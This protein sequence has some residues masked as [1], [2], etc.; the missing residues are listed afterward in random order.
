MKFIRET[1]NEI[2]DLL[3]NESEVFDGNEHLVLEPSAGDGRIVDRLIFRG[4]HK[5]LI[6]CVEL[7]EEK[8]KILKDKGYNAVREDFLKFGSVEMY[9]RIIACPPFKANIDLKHIQIMYSLLA[10]DGILVSLTSPY[11]LTNNESHQIEFRK[12]LEDKNYYLKMLPDNSFMEKGKT[13]PTALIKI[14]K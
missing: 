11:W 10:K 5:N 9:G 1:S 3:I 6:D 14:Y 12:W 8:V 13:E 4:Y 2:I 7:N